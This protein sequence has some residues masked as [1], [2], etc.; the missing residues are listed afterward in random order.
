MHVEDEKMVSEILL[1]HGSADQNLT[2]D[3][4]TAHLV[5]S[6]TV[7]NSQR[8]NTLHGF[9]QSLVKTEEGQLGTLLNAVAHDLVEALGSH[10]R[11]FP[12]LGAGSLVGIGN[13]HHSR[14]KRNPRKAG[15][16]QSQGWDQCI[17][18]SAATANDATLLLQ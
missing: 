10:S 14:A 7:A 12:L 6:L 3:T 5:L 13:T 8:Q 1:I 16:L 15:N 17:N 2:C 4:C 18:S 11:H 9:E